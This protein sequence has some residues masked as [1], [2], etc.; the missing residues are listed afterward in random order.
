MSATGERRR[1]GGGS[2]AGGEAGDTLIEALVMVAIVALVSAVGFPQVHRSL[3]A[4]SGRQTVATVAQVLRE[5]H[6]EAVRR[7]APVAFA[8]SADGRVYGAGGGRRHVTPA[9]VVLSSREAAGG[10]IVF[11]GDGS[12]AGGAVRVTAGRRTALI[13]IAPGAGVVAL[14]SS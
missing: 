14:A 9:G 10:G 4:F 11:Q 8:I 13:T 5:A 6:A 7:D 3:L 2:G 1:P 12:S